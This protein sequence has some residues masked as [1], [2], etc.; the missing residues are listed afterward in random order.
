MESP[1]HKNKKLRIALLSEEDICPPVNTFEKSRNETINDFD[2]ML[3]RIKSN[4]PEHLTVLVS[5]NG[6]K[7]GVDLKTWENRNH[8]LKLWVIEG[9]NLSESP[10]HWS[11]FYAVV[12]KTFDTED[13][14]IG[15]VSRIQLWIEVLTGIQQSSV[16][17]VTTNNRQTVVRCPDVVCSVGKEMDDLFA[18]FV[19]F[20]HVDLQKDDNVRIPSQ[21]DVVWEESNIPFEDNDHY[22]ITPRINQSKTVVNF[23]NIKNCLIRES[24]NNQ[25]RDYVPF[26]FE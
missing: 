19:M 22:L 1:Q 20:C 12:S 26:I 17:V 8:F 11:R 21:P 10:R 4:I 16:F 5:E 2:A 23:E 6:T 14:R 9:K 15:F 18:S 7:T 13:E 25:L 24:S 3:A